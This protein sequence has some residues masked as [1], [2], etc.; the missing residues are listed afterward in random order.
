MLLWMVGLET[1]RFRFAALTLCTGAFFL[2]FFSANFT[3]ASSR[4]LGYGYP[5]YS[6]L[7]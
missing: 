5:S 2:F 1:F 3:D 6:M 7:S 4:L